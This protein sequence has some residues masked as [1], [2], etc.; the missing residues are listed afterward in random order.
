MKYRYLSVFLLILLLSLGA[1]SAQDITASDDSIALVQDN[2]ILS[3][4]EYIIDDSNYDSYFDNETGAILENSNISDGDTIK[5]GNVSDKEFVIDKLLTIT[6]NSSSDVLTN[7]SFYFNSGSDNSTISN[8]NFISYDAQ[9]STISI[10][11]ASNIAI[12]ENLFDIEGAENAGDIFAIFAIYA[13]NLNVQANVISYTGKTNGTAFNFAIYVLGSEDVEVKENVVEIEIPAGDLDWATG[14]GTSEGIVFAACDN[15]AFTDN[16]ITLI[17]NESVGFYPTVYVVHAANSDNVA[18]EG[19]KIEALSEIDYLYGIKV[20]GDNFSVS[21][22]VINVGSTANYACGVEIGNPSSGVVDGNNISVIAPASAYA[23]YAAD[24]YGAGCSVNISNNIIEGLANTFFGVSLF[25]VNEAV[26]EGNSIEAI[27]NYT[28]GVASNAKVLTVNDNVFTLNGSNVGTPLGYD[29]LGVDSVAISAMNGKVAIAYNDITSTGKGLVVIGS[30]LTA[31]RNTINVND[32]GLADS[33]AVYLA[34]DTDV[35]FMNNGINYVGITDGTFINNAMY[36][37]N[38]TI[39]SISENTFEIA[40]PSVD[41]VWK[42][43]PATSGNWVSFPASEGIVLKDNTDLVFSDNTVNLNATDVITAYGYDT[44]YVIDSDNDNAVLD[45][46]FISAI[47]KDY[48]Y[49]IIVSGEDFTISN[50]E[51]QVESESYYANGIDVEGPASGVVSNNSIVL[52]SPTAAYGIYAAM[53]NGNVTME[54]TNNTILAE[55]Y[56]VFGMELGG[57]EATVD[58]NTITL[59]GNYTTGIAAN[60]DSL[61]INDN[62]IIVDGSNVGN[63]YVWDGF[64]VETVAIK[65]ING[66]VF[67]AYN[68]ITSTGKGLFVTKSNLTAGRN[69]I[70]VNDNG[71]ADSYGIYLF[72]DVDVLFMNNV[73][74]FTGKTNG[75]TINNAMYAE[76]STVDSISENYFEIHIPSVDVPWKEIPA[77]SGNWVSFPVSEGIVLKDNADLVFSDNIVNLNATDVITLYGYD[78]IYVVDVDSDNAVIENNIISAFGQ[79]YIYGLIISGEN[80]TVSDN[81]FGIDATYYSCGIDVEG[82]ASG[83]VNDNFLIIYSPTVAYPVY[84][85][86]SNGNVSVEYLNNAIQGIAYAVWGMEL[87]GIDVVADGNHI[88]LDG[89]YTTGIAVRVSG[90]ADITNN[91]ITLDASNIGN[92]SIWDGFG[93]E[94][95]G[96]HALLGDLSAKYNVIT[97]TGNYTVNTAAEG[98]VT[99]NYLVAA[100]LIGD[101]SVNANNATLVENNIPMAN[102]TNYNLTNDTFFL[103]FNENGFIRENITSESLTFIGDFSNLPPWIII[104]RPVKLLS[105]NAVL[106]DMSFNIM[107]D[108]VT[109]DGFMFVSET[110]SEI[111]HVEDAANVSIINNNI[112]VDGVADDNNKVISII[113]SDDVL[114]DNNNITF[115]VETNETFQNIAIHAAGSDNLVITRNT[116]AALLPARSIDWGT[117]MVYSQGVFLDGCD[118]AVLYENIIGVKSN[119]QISTYDTI[120]AVN[121]KGDNAT[122]VEN[123]IGV[124]EAPYGYALVLSGENFDISNNMIVAVQNGTYAC[125]V[126]IDGASDGLIEGNLIYAVADVSAYGIYTANWAGDV[127]ANITDNMILVNSNSA[128]AMSLSG[129]EISAENN[130]IIVQGNYTTGIVT[131][132]NDTVI[133]N[134]TIIANGSNVGTPLGYDMMG[135]QTIGVK[136][137]GIDA[138]VTNNNITSNSKYA[139]E[140]QKDG[141][142]TDNELYAEVLTGDF[143]VDY[144]QDGGVLVA[145]NTPEMELDYKLTND[146]FY[147]YFDDDGVLREQ[148]TGDN[149]TFIGEFSNLV[150]TITINKP[151]TLLSDNATLDSIA[152]SIVADN[153]TVDGFNFIGKSKLGVYEFDNIQIINNNFDIE[154]ANDTDN[155]AVEIVLSDNTVIDNNTIV[156]SVE[157]DGTFINYVIY[158]EGCDNLTISNNDIA[159]DLPARSINWTT[160]TVYSEGVS[161]FDCDNAVLEN[162]TIDVNA[163]DQMST[164]D[165]VYAVNIRGNNAL[166]TD[167][168]IA[169]E[170]AP[171]GYGLVIT[172]EYFEIDDN[173]IAAENDAYSCGIDVESNSNGIIAGNIIAVNGTSAYGIY[174][175]NWAGDVKAE[176]V[177]NAI[178]A[179]G[180]TVFGMSLSGSE[181]IVGN[182]LIVLNGNYTTGIASAIANIT[183]E[184]NTINA[185]GSN[186]GTPAGYDSMGIETTGVHIVSGNATVTN[187]NITTTGEFAVDAKGTGSVTDNYLVAAAYTGDA[188]VDNIAG[189]TLVVNNTPA[190]Q[191]VIIQAEDVVMYYKNGTRYVLKVTDMNGNPLA[192]ENVTLTINGATYGRTTDENGTAS[193][194]INLSPGNYSASVS[195]V[196]T[197]NC[198]NSSIENSIT[199]LSTIY[200]ENLVKMFRNASQYYATFLDGQGNPL[201]NGTEVTFNINGVMYKRLTNE[202]GTARLNINLAAG[203]YIL[204]AIHPVN[205]QQYSNNITVISNIANNTDL[206]KYYKNASQYVVTVIGADGKVVGAGENVTF[207]INGVMYTRQ[208]NESGQA[209]L[210][211]NL[212][213]GNYTITAM[214]GEC[215]ASNNI[216]VLPILYA[217][218]L[219]KKYGTSDQFRALL[220]DGQGKPFAGENITFNINGVF[221]QRTTDSDGYAALNIKL[222]AAVDE[223]IITSS[224]NGTSIS[225]KIIVEP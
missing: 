189:N 195:Y 128:F 197:G 116:V 176:I 109:V 112:I 186:E 9:T 106:S 53:S 45:N 171:Y 18:V 98:E 191:R 177:D 167:N 78:T 165:T 26:V 63:E 153:V 61:T 129:S 39:D 185:T 57:I 175:A 46:N 93:V 125:A 142:V 81:D 100:E 110:L 212:G 34:N 41:V 193:I 119:D 15:L 216:E 94:T 169:M 30:N 10:D 80:F 44:I 64:G 141:T 155:F 217:K 182:N 187:N 88:M 92:M 214:Y 96:I 69:I 147:I 73:I 166:V 54:Y 225:N 97:T 33:Y 136:V 178:A 194:A 179:E 143:A 202:N 6:S 168:L 23:V 14:F 172:G 111:I 1:V 60:L 161:L 66:Q 201:A 65:A 192:N 38:S 24:W 124:I 146:T 84:A 59:E 190:M 210:N 113:M 184:E 180:N 58:Y 70:T 12:C 138:T 77:T 158:A 208:T 47:G 51:I 32:T 62:N 139:V 211:I 2:E 221:Y 102:A 215:M 25:G 173:I 132:A 130:A 205:G 115:G 121:I 117:G 164:Y 56:A 19:N 99:D 148:I 220:L 131:A 42:E 11:N 149:L 49:G 118:N 224:Y 91:E 213:P 36:A 154:G 123:Q 219:V 218:D 133:N 68:N 52:L 7:V 20:D 181:A 95:V 151:I 223:Y 35:L 137:I 50:N 48:I 43:I 37:E 144:A 108:N 199:V 159:A 76:N 140:V 135:V 127:K 74:Y 101:E 122:L 28:T 163:N 75:T 204:T 103:F 13:D 196:G 83:I 87:G 3:A 90:S 105:D 206:V 71:L 152:M 79:D 104:D 183:I 67:L 72:N 162:N 27:G 160:N 157:T 200:G 120:Y 134:N 209:K 31:E 150:P 126:E 145:N 114:I 17:T 170:G 8:L 40:I 107:S 22:N 89:N 198:T 188:A 207:N 16:N 4:S 21:D 156:Y 85:A 82:P 29:S 86:M 203:T 5:L 174:T 222:G 55:A